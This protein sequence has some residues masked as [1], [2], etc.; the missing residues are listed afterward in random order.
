VVPPSGNKKYV[1]I[2]AKKHGASSAHT[3]DELHQMSSLLVVCKQYLQWMS[4]SSK[5]AALAV[6]EQLTC[7]MQA[8]LAVDELQ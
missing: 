1:N 2:P 7:S 4:C 8:V 6:D 5:R 3:I